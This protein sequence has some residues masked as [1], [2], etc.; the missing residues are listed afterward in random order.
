VCPDAFGELKVRTVKDSLPPRF[1]GLFK[2]RFSTKR[3]PSRT[4]N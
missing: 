2:T 3:H 4:A 1:T